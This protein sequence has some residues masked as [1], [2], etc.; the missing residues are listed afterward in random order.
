VKPSLFYQANAINVGVV[1]LVEYKV[2]FLWGTSNGIVEHNVGKKEL[3]LIYTSFQVRNHVVLTVVWNDILLFP[4]V[5]KSKFHLWQMKAGP[6]GDVAWA[7]HR[8]L[9]LEPFI[10][11][12]AVSKAFV[13]G[14]VNGVGVELCPSTETRLFINELNSG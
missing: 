11:P 8:A 7:R 13:V 12:P 6:K 3:L 5:W 4:G 14:V 2:Y 1:V 10:S 9:E